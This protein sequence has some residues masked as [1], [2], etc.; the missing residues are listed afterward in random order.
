[1]LVKLTPCVTPTDFHQQWRFAADYFTYMGTA[2]GVADSGF[3]FNMQN[4]DIVGSR[5]LLREDVGNDCTNTPT[6]SRKN[7]FPD[8]DAGAGA[9]GADTGQ[10]VNRGEVGRC[11]DLP[12][13]DVNGKVFTDA[14]RLPA[15]ITYPCKQ[16]FNGI[17]HWNHRFAMPPLPAAGYKATGHIGVTPDEVGDPGYGIAYCLESPGSAPGN[18][19]V[20][21]CSTGGTALNWTMFQ[22]APLVEDSYQIADAYGNCMQSV[23]PAATA[24]QRLDAWSFVITKPCNGSDLQ[25]WNVP[26]SFSAGPLKAL[27]E[28]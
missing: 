16:A 10:L 24:A 14:N 8:P 28:K 6:L 20:D 4:P 11:I 9:S 22:R 1:M 19:W 12:R 5:V 15:L 7:F 23:G 13:D 17:V 3:C 26:A 2:D 21:K 25:K 18:V 27:G